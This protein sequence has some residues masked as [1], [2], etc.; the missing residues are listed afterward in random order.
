[1]AKRPRRV[2][3]STIDKRLKEGRGSGKG[4]SYI[5]WLFIHDV[6]SKGLAWRRKGWTTGRTHHLLSSLEDNFF[7][8]QDWNPSVSDIREQY[9]LLPIEETLVIAEECN[10]R[11][12]AFATQPDQEYPF[13]L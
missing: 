9:P 2:T 8:I 13:L 1:M 4:A 11:H 7:L 12:P 10:I 6:P 3:E 5:P